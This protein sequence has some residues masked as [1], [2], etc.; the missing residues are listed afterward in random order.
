MMAIGAMTV[1][2]AS[3]PV[4][5]DV[6][7]TV[8][9]VAAL[10]ATVF[11]EEAVL[12]PTDAIPVPTE[13]IPVSILL[14]PVTDANKPP[15]PTTAPPILAEVELSWFD[16]AFTALLLAFVIDEPNEFTPIEDNTA[17]EDVPIV[18]P[19]EPDIAL[20][21]RL[22]GFGTLFIFFLFCC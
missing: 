22:P 16:R 7:T 10:E 12:K 20:Y 21:A 3:V 8:P 15:V 4:P 5:I 13:V 6:P 9:I 17:P 18:A 11:T 14:I 19:I 2:A 1:A